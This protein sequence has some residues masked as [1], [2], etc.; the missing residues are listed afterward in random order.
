MVTEQTGRQRLGRAQRGLEVGYPQVGRVAEQRRR[1][2]EAEAQL[3][4]LVEVQ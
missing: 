2:H 1:E 4:L 3:R